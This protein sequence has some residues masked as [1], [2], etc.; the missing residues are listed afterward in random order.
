MI[1]LA[2]DPTNSRQAGK[3]IAIGQI[4]RDVPRHAELLMSARTYDFIVSD[5]E[6]GRDHFDN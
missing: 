2:H 5:A 4:G 6:S 3:A 1:A